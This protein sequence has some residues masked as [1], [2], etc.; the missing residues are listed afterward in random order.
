MPESNYIKCPF[1]QGILELKAGKQ[2]CTECGTK[3]EIDDRLECIFADPNDLR[4]PIKGNLCSK[5]GLLQDYGIDY[6]LNCGHPLSST[7]Q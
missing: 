4:L 3:I 2:R 6:C 7:I 1:C 5:C